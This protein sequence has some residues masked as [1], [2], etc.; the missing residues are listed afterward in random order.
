MMLHMYTRRKI[1][2]LTAFLLFGVMQAWAQCGVN[3]PDG[4]RCEAP[5]GTN[6]EF[7]IC[8]GGVCQP[9]GLYYPAG[10]KCGCFGDECYDD[11]CDGNGNCQCVLT[12]AS[13]GTP[14]ASEK[15]ICDGEETCDGITGRNCSGPVNNPAA[16]CDDGI[17]CTNDCNP[18][19][20]CVTYPI[21][22]LCDDANICTIDECDTTSLM[23]G[24]SNACNPIPACV[25]DPACTTFP[26]ELLAFDGSLEGLQ[27][28][29]NWMT[30]FELNNAGFEIW[31]REA[32][33]EFAKIGFV[34]GAGTVQEAQLYQFNTLLPKPGIYIVKLRQRDLNGA[35][36]DSRVL[37]FKVETS[38]LFTL[39]APF[40]NPSAGDAVIRFQVEHVGTSCLRLYDEK[41]TL[42]RTLFEEKSEPGK[43]YHITIKEGWLSE[44]IYFC[45]LKTAHG[46]FTQKLIRY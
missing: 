11:F 4:E 22:A 14:C 24:C 40:P 32:Q 36:Y 16:V 31:M 25:N 26:I 12:P 2:G 6:C 39:Y 29:L 7:Y 34:A 44:G 20:G 18:V 30:G 3:I 35:S 13:F 46:S 45:H 1:L 23:A 28:S 5:G 38:N 33:D 15:N 19:D 8:V 37:R 27:L 9:S 42:I 17:A 10:S 43:L 21:D 41:G